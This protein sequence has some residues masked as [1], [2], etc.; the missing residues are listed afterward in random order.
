MGLGIK[1]EGGKHVTLAQLRRNLP[2]F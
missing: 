1:E 2:I